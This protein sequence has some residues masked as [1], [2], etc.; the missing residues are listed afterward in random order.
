MAGVDLGDKDIKAGA[1]SKA[2]A[3]QRVNTTNPQTILDRSGSGLLTELAGVANIR[4]GSAPITS[5][6]YITV[7]VTADDGTTDS[8]DFTIA[9]YDSNNAN[10][11]DRLPFSFPIWKRYLDNCEVIV[12]PHGYTGGSTEIIGVWIEGVLGE[13]RDS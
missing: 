5:S 2:T 1:A 6:V 8:M 4:T 3:L 10:Q 11:Q 12:T 7:D 13:S 9:T